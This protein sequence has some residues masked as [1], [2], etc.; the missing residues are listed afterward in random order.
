M[1]LISISEIY[2]IKKTLIEN[3]NQ[4][5]QDVSNSKILFYIPE[6]FSA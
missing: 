5:L 4:G 2:K 3:Y 6:N 1:E